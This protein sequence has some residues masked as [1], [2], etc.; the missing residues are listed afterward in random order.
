MVKAIKKRTKA[1]TPA[2]P[3]ERIRGSKANPEGSAS[4]SRGG[5]EIGE[6]AQKALE[7]MRDSHNER[8]TNAQRQVNM[9]QLKAVYRRG[10]GAFSVSHRPGMTRNGWALARVRA[11]LKLV[12]KGERKKA[13]TGDL[14]LLPDGHPSKPAAEKKTELNLKRYDHIDF[15]PPKG[16]QEAGRRALEVRESKPISQRGMTS[17]GISRARDLANGRKMS[18]D[19]VRRMLA[20]FTRH[21]SDK[22]G[23]TWNS[24]GK[25]WQAWQGWGGDAGFAWARKVVNQMNAADKKAQALRAYS[26][27]LSA[28]HTYDIPDGLTIGRPFKTLSLGQVSSRMSGKDIGKEI[29]R[30]MLSEMVRVFNARRAEDPVVIDWQHAT[31]PYQD[32]PPAPP[33][34]GNALGLIADLELRDDGLYAIPAYNERGLNVVSE[35]GGVLWSSPEFLAGDVFDRA[36]GSHIGTAQLLAVTLTPRPAQSHSKIDR[37]TLNERFAD[38]DD[39]ANM[40]LDDLREMLIAKDEMVK[41]LEAQIK[42]MKKDA[43]SKISSDSAALEEHDKDKEEKMGEDE[44]KE[45]KMAEDKKDHYKMS[46]TV[47]P[48]LLS[49]FNALREKNEQMAKRLETI[50]QEKREIEKREAVSALLRDGR[51]EPSQESVAGKA[52]E[53]REVQPEFWQMFSERPAGAAV[54]LQEV[55][56]GASGREINRQSLD[57]EIKKLAAEKSISYSEALNQFRTSNPDFYTKAFGG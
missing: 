8:Y 43:E 46:E 32:G 38:M 27:A 47:S 44:D 16:A 40:D 57:A 12:G 51:I 17:V 30:E 26:E 54:P 42:D 35:A 52:W 39:L 2:K 29:T 9:G 34:S 24:Q 36:G 14:D 31:S 4:G 10:A 11:F 55:G 22:Q 20:Y 15:T 28:Q 25:G 37:V 56:H 45:K 33:E 50:E 18:P 49:E 7:N 3:Q 13:Y 48:E 23:S 6:R 41:R 19:T 53:L 5:I 21:Q 1:Q